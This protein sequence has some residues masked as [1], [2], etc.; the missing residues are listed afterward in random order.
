M[1]PQYPREA[2]RRLAG[3][4]HGVN[5]YCVHGVNVKW[6]C[7]LDLVGAVGSAGWQK[8]STDRTSVDHE[9][10][11]RSRLI[12]RKRSRVCAKRSAVTIAPQALADDRNRTD[13]LGVVLALF[14][15]LLAPLSLLADKAVV[16]LVIAAALAG[17]VVLGASAL[18]WRVIDRPLAG[19]LVLF[20]AWCLAAA[21]WSFHP[22]DAANLAL[23]VG[24]LLL[25]LLYLAGLVRLLDDRQRRRVVHGFCLGLAAAAAVASID[26]LFGTPIFDL[27][28]GEARRENVALA[29]LN[30]GVSALA[31]LVWPFA[32]LA[33]RQ[34]WHAA[35]LL[36]PPAFF[37]LTLFSQSSASILALGAGL[38]A[39]AVACLGRVATRLVLA[40]AIAGALLAAPLAVDLMQRTGLEQSDLI[41]KNGL[42]RLHIWGVVS[43]RI[44][45]RPFFGWG[46]DASPDLPT[47]GVEPFAPDRK[48]I[49]SHPHNGALQIMVET[50][51]VGSLLAMAVLALIAW[52]IDSLATPARVCATAMLVTIL[53]IACTAYGLWQSHWLAL[54]GAAAAVFVAVLPAR[55]AKTASPV[56]GRGTNQREP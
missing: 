12:A 48:I 32:A 44:A 6:L 54:I 14:A 31:I 20:T 10:R 37:A 21:W 2:I 23:R 1:S 5:V 39:A 40:A 50:G 29:R 30:R 27:L 56:A 9:D 7:G 36:L 26:L 11:R 35:A 13:R 46:F 28:E 34:G 8:A 52:R 24:A 4:V 16:P 38:L 43:D 18:P 42:H 17:G 25:V 53:G 49:P 33:W 41:H 47:A 45:E 55:Q 51:I 15:L 22:L 19:A 3:Q